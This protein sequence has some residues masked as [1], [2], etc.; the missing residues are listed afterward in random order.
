MSGI[1]KY[2]K[3]AKNAVIKPSDDIEGKIIDRISRVD[4]ADKSL[5][6]DSFLDFFKKS[7][8]RLYLAIE[9]IKNNPG[10]FATLIVTSVFIFIFLIVIVKIFLGEE[11]AAGKRYRLSSP[12]DKTQKK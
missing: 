6:D 2:L 10:I 5:L 7:N 11:K 9:K 12:E 3:I 8:S 4:T 1:N